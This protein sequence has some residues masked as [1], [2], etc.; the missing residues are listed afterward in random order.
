[1]K[2]VIMKSNALT[3]EVQ[4]G[5][6]TNSASSRIQTRD[7]KI[8][9]PVRYYAAAQNFFTSAVTAHMVV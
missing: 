4:Y 7:L 9:S 2:G 5:H 8:W 6:E 1:M 3:S